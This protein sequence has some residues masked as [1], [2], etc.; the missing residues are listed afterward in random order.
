LD[1]SVRTLICKIPPDHLFPK[2]RTIPLFG[3]ERIP[4][5]SQIFFGVLVGARGD[6]LIMSIQL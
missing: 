2:G 5:K 6:F 1:S 3:K 4:K